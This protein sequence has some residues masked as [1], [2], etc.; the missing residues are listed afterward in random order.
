MFDH[1]C[2]VYLNTSAI[3]LA[4]I[5]SSMG[6]VGTITICKIYRCAGSYRVPTITRVWVKKYDDADIAMD[7]YLSSFPQPPRAVQGLKLICCSAECSR[8]SCKR[9]M[10]RCRCRVRERRIR[11]FQGWLQNGSSC[12][13]RA[14]RMWGE[15]ATNIVPLP[16]GLQMS[17]QRIGESRD[18]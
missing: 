12:Y 10:R 4:P 1:K 16:M 6:S 9:A 14:G 18:A 11:A 15:K 2:N 17:Q 13:H 8:A 5:S 7:R 3:A